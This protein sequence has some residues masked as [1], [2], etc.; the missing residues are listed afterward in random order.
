MI[1]EFFK[2]TRSI[3]LL[4]AF[5][6][7]SGGAWAQGA[8]I[9]YVN[10][11]GTQNSLIVTT[12]AL[13]SAYNI[14]TLGM[15]A[16]LLADADLEG[17]YEVSVAIL[18]RDASLTGQPAAQSSNLVLVVGKRLNPIWRVGLYAD[19]TMATDGMSVANLPPGSPSVGGYVVWRPSDN[20]RD[21]QV[22]L[23]AGWGNKAMSVQRTGG[24]GSEGGQGVTQLESFGYQ[25]Q[26]SWG[27]ALGKHSSVRPYLGLRYVRV[28]EQGY[29][30][31][32]N[33]SAPLSLGS[34][35][36]ESMAVLAGVQAKVPWSE[37]L[38]LVA[39]VGVEQDV[40]HQGGAYAAASQNVAGLVPVALNTI[41]NPTRGV[42]ELALQGFVTPLQRLQVGV[43]FAEQAFASQVA[44]QV[45]VGYVSG[46]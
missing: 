35:V 23:S 18:G 37:R 21:A 15:Q 13:R 11:T 40:A 4:W 24:S 3:F 44:V 7:Q 31:A 2:I 1:H 38:A 43:K 8:A 5:L 17:P 27:I 36:Q 32:E 33:I 25:V 29:T 46:F 19:Q 9:G 10:T 26:G 42:L 28:S 41:Y 22:R 39:H 45:E 12:Y 14:Q 20:E 16:N 6:S 30:E 34:M